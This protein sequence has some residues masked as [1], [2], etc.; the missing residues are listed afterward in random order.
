MVKLST[1]SGI[2]CELRQHRRSRRL[3]QTELAEQA[4]LSTKT[5]RLLESTRGTLA[6][7]DATL[8]TLGLSVIGR[9]LPAGDSLGS[10]VATLR[11]NRGISQRQPA[12]LVGVTPPTILA[13]ERHRRGRLETL[14][15]ILAR[16]GA[17]AYLAPAGERRAFYSHA[18]N[19]D[20][21]FLKGRLRFGRTTQSAPFPSAIVVWGADPEA[22]ARMDAAFP[23]AWRMKP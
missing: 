11:R 19:A 22:L 3:T 16:L 9:N 1:H 4:R 12:E 20:V 8:A 13:I 2:G 5:V 14:A 18:G 10:S 21:Y 6:S 17:G 7:W 23:D 15:R